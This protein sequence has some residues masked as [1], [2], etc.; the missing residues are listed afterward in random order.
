MTEFDERTWH[1]LQLHVRPILMGPDAD[2]S[3]IVTTLDVAQAQVRREPPG[4]L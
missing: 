3:H 2:A 4:T 1:L